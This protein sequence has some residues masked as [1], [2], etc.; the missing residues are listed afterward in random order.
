MKPQNRYTEDDFSDFL[1]DL[2]NSGEL[3]G[4]KLGIT[5]LVKD[6]YYYKKM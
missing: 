3:E 6:K 5:K 2:I 1:N 4:K